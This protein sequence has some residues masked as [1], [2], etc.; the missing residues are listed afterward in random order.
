MSLYTWSEG[1]KVHRLLLPVNEM[2]HR[3]CSD[4]SWGR[5]AMRLQ[6]RWTQGK[7]FNDFFLFLKNETKQIPFLKTKIRSRIKCISEL[8][9]LTEAKAVF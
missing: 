1:G 3:T 5:G 9:D 8:S 6:K 7:S 2:T 4:P